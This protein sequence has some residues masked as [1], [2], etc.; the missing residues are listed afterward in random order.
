MSEQGK[1]IVL[2]GANNLGKS[3]QVRFLVQRLEQE[4]V[5]AKLLKYP[6]YDLE[7]TGPQIN[8]V[9]R[10]GVA[11][12]DEGL[13]DLFAR[14]RRDFEPILKEVLGRGIWVV[15]EDYTGTGVSW[16]VTHNI[17]LA[18]MEEI[19]KGLLKEDLAILLDGERFSAG[20][21]RE[22]RH[23]AGSD[24][25]K[26]RQVHLELASRYGW[27][28]VNANQTMERVSGAIWEIVRKQVL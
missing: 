26:A 8:A 16:G 15:A 14:N 6:I 4:G 24:W 12:T 1:F 22:H 27:E 13:Q 9:L 20:I 21:E 2:Y 25:E 23:E 5:P 18:T 28:V 17:P 19:N 10:K 7:P 11:M 3:T